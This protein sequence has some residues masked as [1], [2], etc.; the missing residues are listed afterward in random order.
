[1]YGDREEEEEE[2]EEEEEREKRRSMREFWGMG[3]Q[4]SLLSADIWKHFSPHLHSERRRPNS[5]ITH[6]S[7]QSPTPTTDT[8]THRHTDTQTQRAKYTTARAKTNKQTPTVNN[9]GVGINLHLYGYDQQSKLLNIQKHKRLHTCTLAHTHTITPPSGPRNPVR[10]PANSK[11]RSRLEHF[12][13]PATS[14]CLH[15]PTSPVLSFSAFSHK[16]TD[17]KCTDSILVPGHSETR[18]TAAHL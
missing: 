16:A 11:V 2:A 18:R 7:S 13:P 5:Y 15:H 9:L 12:S 8:H 17:L 1:M 6:S 14:V 3:C 4:L 10:F